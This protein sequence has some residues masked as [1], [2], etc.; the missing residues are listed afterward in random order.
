MTRDRHVL[1]I[2]AGPAGLSAARELQ[3]Q[4]LQPLVF[5]RLDRVGGISRTEQYKGYRFDI[6]GHRFYTQIPV[7]NELWHTVLQE[8]FE[9]R[10][11]QSRI[12]YN[13]R[14]F[15]YPLK[16]GQTLRQLGPLESVHILLSYLSARLFP[17]C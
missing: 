1:I 13:G 3:D 14:F 6:G 12:Y 16:L 4:G 11:R 8:D 15:P 17:F 10:P 2:G 7:V 9:L 5:E